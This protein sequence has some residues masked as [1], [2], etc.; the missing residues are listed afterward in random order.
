[1]SGLVPGVLE[2][3]ET[4]GDAAKYVKP[5]RLRDH[6]EQEVPRRI[7][8]RG[9]AARVNQSPDAIVMAHSNWLARLDQLPGPPARPRGVKPAPAP[10][11]SVESDPAPAFGAEPA[12]APAVG[13]SSA[14]TV[15]SAAMRD[16]VRVAATDSP[17]ALAA[18]LESARAAAVPGVDDIAATAARVA[19]PFGPDSHETQCG[20][21]VLGARIVDFLIVEGHAEYAN[22]EGNDLRVYPKTFAESVLVTFAGGAGTVVPAVPGFLTALTFDDGELVD[23]ALEPSVNHGRWYDYR[24]KISEVRALRGVA[25]AAS[26]QG[27]FRLDGPEALAVAQRMQFAKGVDPALALYAAYAYYDLQEL[28]RLGRMSAYLRD[29]LGTRL[30]DVAMLARELRDVRVNRMAGVVPFV[31]MLAQGW[32]LVDSSRVRLHPAL[33]GI[34]ARV[35]ESLWSLYEPAGVDMLRSAMQSRD[36]R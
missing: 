32:A 26:R 29:D 6:L 18:A 3:G 21:K 27:R 34:A 15:P 17:A 33:D 8:A 35:R 9:L 10:A 12:P 31:P 20:I 14:G 19:A 25:A 13:G 5:A 2:P 22:A 1:M 11:L 23:V 28:D 7:A 24:E 30:F 16:L 36:V 4:A